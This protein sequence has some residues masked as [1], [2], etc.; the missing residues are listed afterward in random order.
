MKTLLQ[1]SSTL[2]IRTPGVGKPGRVSEA[3]VESGDLYPTLV[4]L[5]Q[6]QFTQ[7]QYP[8][9]GKSLV[10]LLTGKVPA[11]RDVAVSYWQDAITVRTL[12]HRLIARCNGDGFKDITLY[13][14]SR[15]PDSTLNIAQ[16]EPALVTQL[17]EKRAPK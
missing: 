10:P 1:C 8:L 5:C 4:E 17:L 7:T 16:K 3:L 6:P 15:D 2:M 13:D 14:L 9:D 11:V 12:T